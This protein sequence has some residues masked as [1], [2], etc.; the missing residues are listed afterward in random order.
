MSVTP[1]TFVGIDV[2]KDKADVCLRPGGKHWRFSLQELEKAV[3]TLQAAQPD[4]VILEPTGGYELPWVL[5]CHRAGLRVARPHATRMSHHAR[6]K[7]L[8]KSDKLDADALAHYGECYH[9]ELRIYQPDESQLHL[10]MLY[11]RRQQ[12]IAMRVEEK[13]RYKH[14]ELPASIRQGI[15]AMIDVFTRQIEAVDQELQQRIEQEPVLR[16][17]YALLLSMPGVGAVT[18]TGLICL[19]P[20]LGQ[21]DRK[22]IAALVGV[23]PFERSSG[24]WQGK[25]SIRGG[26]FAVRQLLYM[27]ALSATR[28]C[29]VIRAFYEQLRARG[30]TGKQALVACMHKMLRVLNAMLK[31]N[32]LFLPPS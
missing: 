18:A 19:L 1:A 20:E 3:Q 30:K 4:W 23:V 24:K 11:Q 14:P 5:A 13:N 6:G 22:E 26:R 28:Y 27:A 32:Q 9:D 12:L 8:A 29:P 15:Q 25:A 7:R 21:A 17:N 2:S 31:T 10:R 16:E